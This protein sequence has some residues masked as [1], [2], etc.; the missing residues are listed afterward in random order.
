MKIDINDIK[1]GFSELT[2]EVFAGK[3]N[4]DGT[5]WIEKVNIT[6][7]FEYIIKKRKQYKT[8]QP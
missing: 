5:K 2:G 3:T 4:K 1:I 6:S 7:Q 8:K